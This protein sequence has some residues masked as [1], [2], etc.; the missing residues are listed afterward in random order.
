[1]RFSEWKVKRD[2]FLALLDPIGS[3]HKSVIANYFLDKARDGETNPTLICRAIY[4]DNWHYR[5]RHPE[6]AKDK[7]H[8]VKLLEIMENPEHRQKCLDYAEYAIWWASLSPETAQEIRVHWKN[9][10]KPLARHYKEEWMK[11]QRPTDGQ[12]QILRSLGC[13]EMPVNRLEASR[14]IDTRMD[15]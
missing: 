5:E 14:W 15:V 4:L 9:E 1:M 7:P 11:A 10:S 2:E 13:H 3:G 6:R 12:I 8:V